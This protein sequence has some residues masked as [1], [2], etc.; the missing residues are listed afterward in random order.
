MSLL[1]RIANRLILGNST[2]H[3]DPEDRRREAFSCDADEMEAW[4]TE[5]DS[6]SRHLFCLKFPGTGGRAERAG[7]HPCEIVSPDG[8]ETWA[9]NPPGY[10]TSSGSA[11]V[12]KMPQVCDAAWQAV[13][14]RAAGTPVIVTGNSLGCM[15]ALY[16]AARYPIAGLLLRNPAPVHQLIR[17]RYSWWSLGLANYVSDQVPEAMDAVANSRRSSVPALF[18]T[19]DRDRK[20]PPA[21]QQEVF[22]AYGGDLEVFTLQDADHHTPLSEDQM[23][24]YKNAVIDWGHKLGL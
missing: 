8:H 16:V 11:S 4:V 7:P 12:S 18:V 22:S 14:H 3:I 15:Y 23:E 5:S 24:D 19:S 17:R 2:N 13:Q 9:I 21:I 6:D 10:G 20:I 1:L